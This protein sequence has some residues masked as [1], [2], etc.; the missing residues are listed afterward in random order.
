MNEALSVI[1]P[2][3]NRESLVIRTLDSVYAQTYRPVELIVV[4]NNSTDNTLGR[5]EEWMENHQ[6]A[7]FRIKILKETTPGACA[8]RQTGFRA[9]TS[10]IVYFFD[11][12]DVMH[13]QLAERAMQEFRSYPATDIVCWKVAYGDTSPGGKRAIK[14]SSARNILRRHMFNSMLSTQAYAVRSDYFRQHGG[15]NLNL[16][17]WNDWE[18]GLRLLLGNPAIRCLS[19]TLATIYPQKDSITGTDHISR[20]GEWEKAIEAMERV[21]RNQPEPLRSRLL[22]MLL[23]RRVNLAALYNKEGDERIAKELL[24]SSLATAGIARWKKSLL[25][26]IYT[27]TSRGGRCAYLLWR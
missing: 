11:S 23:Y 19:A 5:V 4:D 21:S 6:D 20:Q 14:R 18:L 24:E 17:C 25:R 8:A 3:Y 2:V 10:G 13:P 9:A 22:G 26:F 15:W 16:P 1:I 27:Y 12:D 7:T